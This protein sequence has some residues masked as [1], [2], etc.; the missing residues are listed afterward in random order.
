MVHYHTMSEHWVLFVTNWAE[1][2]GTITT[3]Q[4]PNIG[5]KLKQGKVDEMAI[6]TSHAYYEVLYK[7]ALHIV[8]EEVVFQKF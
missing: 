6:K 5:E 7:T 1:L 8:E 4:Q 2:G 3:E